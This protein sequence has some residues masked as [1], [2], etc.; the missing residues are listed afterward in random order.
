MR[1]ELKRE[2]GLLDAT[3]IN[4]G[5]IIASAIFLVPSFIAQQLHASSLVILAWLV[6]GA[7]SLL[8]ALSIAELGA[9]F[10]AA[11]GLFVYLREAYGP[12][13]GFLYGWANAV[14]INPASIAAIAVGFATYVGHFVPLAG[15]GIK[16]VP[17][18]S[19]LAL[20]AP[21]SPALP[22]PPPPPP[23]LPPPTL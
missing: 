11:G 3:M 16:P 4:L 20:P 1:T 9:A 17:I 23:P 19:L 22:P 10:P 21:N 12:L 7:V 18:A 14:V 13:W 8:G 6:G 5:T 15:G 2:L